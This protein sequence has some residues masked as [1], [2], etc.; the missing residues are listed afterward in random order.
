MAA[1]NH[2]AGQTKRFFRSSWNPKEVD[3]QHLES[4]IMILLHNSR[5]NTDKLEGVQWRARRIVWTWSTWCRRDGGEEKAK[6]YPDAPFCFLRMAIHKPMLGLSQRCKLRRQEKRNM[7]CYRGSYEHLFE[8]KKLKKIGMTRVVEP[9][10]RCLRGW[11][12]PG[13]GSPCLGLS[14]VL[15][16]I[17]LW[18][19]PYS[20]QHF[21]L[22]DLQ[23]ALPG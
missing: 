17:S 16:L 2:T 3:G 7:S 20:K 19:W 22:G 9:Q 4:P 5:R 8:K 18:Y 13:V 12:I 6:Q 23:E 21:G 1:C 15:S 11:G 14:K 10:Q